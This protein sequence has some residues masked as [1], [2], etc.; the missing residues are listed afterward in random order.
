ML[1]E[2]LP[3]KFTFY[4]FS[5]EFQTVHFK[6]WEFSARL[7]FLFERSVVISMKQILFYKSVCQMHKHHACVS[8]FSSS[9]KTKS[10]CSQKGKK[11]REIRVHRFFGLD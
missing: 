2:S 5:T 4:A 7:D 8:L 1:A 3:L 9:V 11:S 10:V 6:L